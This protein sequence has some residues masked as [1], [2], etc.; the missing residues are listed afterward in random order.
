M[1]DGANGHYSSKQQ[2]P[3]DDETDTS[4]ESAALA[5]GAA[6]TAAQSAGRSAATRGGARA[7]T[8]RLPI[9]S[10]TAA[11]AGARASK[12]VARGARAPST[13]ATRVVSRGARA[14]RPVAVPRTPHVRGVVPR[15][16]TPKLSSARIPKA[17][18]NTIAKATDRASRGIDV[19]SAG[20]ETPESTTSN[21]QNAARK[22]TQIKS[23]TQII[24]SI[25][26]AAKQLTSFGRIFVTNTVL[27][28]A[29]FGTYE[30]IIEHLAPPSSQDMTLNNAESASN[31]I[32][33]ENYAISAPPQLDYLDTEEDEDN[34]D[35]DRATLP[36]H[37][38]AGAMGGAAHAV[39]SLALEV[40]VNAS[41]DGLQT[42]SKS[43]NYTS[44]IA[45][46]PI[47]LQ[48][49]TLS[50]SAKS[51][52]HHSLA[53][54]VLFGSYQLTKRLL[55]NHLPTSEVTMNN[56]TTTHFMLHQ[57]P[58]LVVW[59]GN[60]NMSHLTLQNSGWG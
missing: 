37:F 35:M 29:V 18:A 16:S 28:M 26:H 38:F 60:S 14:P 1:D 23:T 50:Y 55:L 41:S 56:G 10:Q 47:Q 17:R 54:S 11:K 19:L 6:R 27:G 52:L 53:H 12:T 21:T 51:I 34:D 49:P 32:R 8:G 24:K 15:S 5:R 4:P 33:D 44:T 20:L 30:G 7:I 22:S 36:Q 42:A 3:I 45:M 39:L 58:R 43:T 46:K 48:V 9:A 2:S 57:L 31:D 25:T 59:L 40:K 13:A